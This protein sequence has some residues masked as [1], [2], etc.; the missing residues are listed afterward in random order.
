M[1]P[2]A[3]LL[4]PGDDEERLVGILKYALLLIDP[5]NPVLALQNG[6]DV[7]L[8]LLLVL[9]GEH[10]DVALTV[11]AVDNDVA[12][13][14]QY[15]VPNVLL[16]R[17]EIRD[18]GGRVEGRAPQSEAELRRAGFVYL[19]AGAQLGDPLRTVA[20][21]GRMGWSVAA[22]YR[23]R[24]PGTYRSSRFHMKATMPSGLS[25]RANSATALS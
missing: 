5:H 4:L 8:E 23:S 14:V 24:C 13:A 15:V 3:H 2:L 21:D 6:V 18:V 7:I 17:L 1:W 20:G 12:R 16:L 10:R 19:V 11:R 9:R 25:T 22:S